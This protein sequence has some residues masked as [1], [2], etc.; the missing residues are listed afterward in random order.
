MQYRVFNATAKLKNTNASVALEV[1]ELVN[2]IVMPMAKLPG[3]KVELK[4]DIVVKSE[5]PF[6]ANT[7]RAVKENSTA[8]K[9]INPEFSED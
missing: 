2:E 7:V 3:V 6:D 8:L 4:L 9:L 5:S 1:Q